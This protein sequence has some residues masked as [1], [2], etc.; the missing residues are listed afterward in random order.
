M[1]EGMPEWAH[2]KVS[3]LDRRIP[4]YLR[5]DIFS[6]LTKYPEDWVWLLHRD[7][8][9][10]VG[11]APNEKAQE[12]AYLTGWKVFVLQEVAREYGYRFTQEDKDLDKLR[13][14]DGGPYRPD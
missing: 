10:E 3:I 1:I 14:V 4:R 8:D 13:F 7:G 6:L 2:A 11:H 5:A 9:F 12:L